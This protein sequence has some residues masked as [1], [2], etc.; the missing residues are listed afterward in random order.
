MLQLAAAVSQHQG[1]AVH[2]PG[3]HHIPAFGKP[4]QVIYR[5]GF[6]GRQHGAGV[7]YF[8]QTFQ[9]FSRYLLGGGVGKNDAGFLFQIFQQV[10]RNVVVAVRH[11]GAVVPEIGRIGL[12]D[13]GDKATHQF[14]LG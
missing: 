3:Q 11:A 7:A 1:Q 8:G 5:F 13:G 4:Y 6:A 10:N 9:N 2:L 12:F 14:N